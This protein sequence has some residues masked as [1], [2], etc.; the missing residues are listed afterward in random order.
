MRKVD[1]VLAELF[2]KL[3]REGACRRRRR[4]RPRVPTWRDAATGLSYSL[5]AMVHA[6]IN[7]LF[8]P[9]QAGKHLGVIEQ[10]LLGPDRIR[11]AK[12]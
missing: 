5:L 4:P 6:I 10:H 11:V 12:A 9:E 3:C 2:F 1:P 8:T 7:G